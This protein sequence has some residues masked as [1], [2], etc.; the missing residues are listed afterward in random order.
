MLG[1]KV[2][3]FIA[4]AFNYFEFRSRADQWILARHMVNFVSWREKKLVVCRPV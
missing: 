2:E 1:S 3:M 4:G